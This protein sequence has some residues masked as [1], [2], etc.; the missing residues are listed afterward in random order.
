M[1][2]MNDQDALIAMTDADIEPAK[3]GDTLRPDEQAQPRFSTV[4]QTIAD[5]TTK[6]RE[7]AT[8]RALGLAQQG[9]ARATDALTQLA[10]MLTEAAGQVDEKLGPQYGQY[11]RS[12]AEQVSGFTAS[13]DAKSVDDLV[14]DVRGFVRQS[15]G[16]AIGAAAAIGFVVARLLSSGLDQRDQA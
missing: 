6:A 10:G 8:D 12:A 9:K 4:K 14:D 5:T 13:I 11:A 15:P 7:Q 3:P 1:A 16:V 2:D